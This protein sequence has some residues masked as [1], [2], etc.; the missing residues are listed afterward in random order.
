MKNNV[1]SSCTLKRVKLKCGVCGDNFHSEIFEYECRR[2]KNF[3]K[4]YKRIQILFVLRLILF[5]VLY[6]IFS[7]I[8]FYIIGFFEGSIYLRYGGML[9]ISPF[10]IP[11][12]LKRLKS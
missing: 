11:F 10:F 7:S 2:C 8:V 5:I 9:I 3:P 6:P 1:L 12:L 4:A